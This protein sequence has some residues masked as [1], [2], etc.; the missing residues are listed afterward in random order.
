[1]TKGLTSRQA[2]VLKFIREHLSEHG[3]PPT[4]REVAA[5]F[6]FRSPRA[7]HDHMKALEKR[8]TCAPSP[9]CPGPWK[10]WAPRASPCWG[11]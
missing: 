9:G 1:M 8:D 6:G 3:Y 2:Q 4:V 7:A 11:A 5:Y 10:C